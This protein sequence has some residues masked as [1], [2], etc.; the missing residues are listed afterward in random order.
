[1]KKIFILA[2]ILF[3]VAIILPG[4]SSAQ[5]GKSDTARPANP[6]EDPNLAMTHQGADVADVGF[7]KE[8]NE[9]KK[10]QRLTD[11]SGNSTPENSKAS[12]GSGTATE[13]P[14]NSDGAVH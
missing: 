14:A 1:M 2:T 8:C 3:S 4:F 11:T 12:T 13:V 6:G 10:H 5:T 9:W 7:C